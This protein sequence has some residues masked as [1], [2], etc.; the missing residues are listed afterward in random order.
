M[1][2]TVGAVLVVEISVE[3]EF[4]D[5]FNHWYDEEHIP[6]RLHYP[7]FISAQRFH[8]PDRPHTYLAVY[9]LENR[10]AALSDWYMSREPSEWTKR[11]MPHWTSMQRVVWA[12]LPTPTG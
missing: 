5:E 11:I 7:G 4:E 12:A 1:V 3:P 9:G 2:D 10:D 6:E 8:D